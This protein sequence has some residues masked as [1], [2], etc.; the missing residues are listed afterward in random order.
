MENIASEIVASFEDAFKRYFVIE[1]R[2]SRRSFW[3]FVAGYICV[4][5]IISLIAKLLSANLG[6]TL[7]WL[8]ELVIMIPSFTIGIRR[9]HDI[10]KSGWLEL[11]AF[12]PVIGWIILVVF[13]CQKGDEGSN[14]YGAPQ[15][16]LLPK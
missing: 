10:N 3:L 11:L 7:S 4:T 1:G 15:Q 13:A 14:E 6:K 8:F 12:V 9:L 2:T 5:I 16:A